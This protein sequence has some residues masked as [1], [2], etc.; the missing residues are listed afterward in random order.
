MEKQPPLITLRYPF[1]ELVLVLAIWIFCY[2]ILFPFIGLALAA[3]IFHIYIG[4]ILNIF[5]VDK[6]SANSNYVSALKFVQVFSELGFFAPAL[7][8]AFLMGYKND[9][10]KFS[11]TSYLIPAVFVIGIVLLSQPLVNYLG[12]LNSHLQLP[13]FLNGVQQSIKSWEDKADATQT[14][15][16]QMPDI[17]ELLINIIVVAAIPAICEEAFLP[18]RCSKFL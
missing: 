6:L 17:K 4:D 1:L 11:R 18:G 5:D 14:L 10:L 9:Y 16:L 7:F 3:P 15:F 8:F 13:S 2:L 12:V